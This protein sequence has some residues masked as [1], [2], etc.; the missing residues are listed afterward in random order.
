[1]L[2][3]KKTHALA[4]VLA[5]CLC[6]SLFVLAAD[7]EY[8]STV[9]PLIS[10]SYLE[11]RLA[12]QKTAYEDEITA[13]EN[14]TA[15]LTAEIESL[16]S[17][18]DLLKKQISDI[19]VGAV[20]MGYEVIEMQK[21]Q[22]LYASSDKGI[23]IIL[24]SGTATVVSPFANQGISDNTIGTDLQKGTAIGLNHL[25]LIP[26]GGDGRG[27]KITSTSAFVMV[28]GEYTIGK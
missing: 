9:D 22:V 8:D 25:L 4:A 27:I 23:E 2:K 17:T 15:E 26:R 1:M 6:L 7:E 10:L 21:G 14:R 13:L 20:G 19:A 28:R 11:R 16:K 12:E 5:V 3:I 18:I 24:R